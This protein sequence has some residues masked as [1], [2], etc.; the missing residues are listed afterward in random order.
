MITM[1]T[2]NFKTL[3]IISESKVTDNW[4]NVYLTSA[5]MEGRRIAWHGEDSYSVI[6]TEK[7]KIYTFTR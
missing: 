2:R 1:T 7:N 5:R 4:W 3:D 6:F